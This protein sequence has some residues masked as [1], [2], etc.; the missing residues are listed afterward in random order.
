MRW[1]WIIGVGFLAGAVAVLAVQQ[2]AL[3]FFHWLGWAQN[4]PYRMNPTQP[5]GVAQVWSNAFFGGL[6]GIVLAAAASRF[7]MPVLL[8]GL[9][10]GAIALPLV[11]WFV[12]APIRGQPVAQ[13]FNLARMWFSPLING[14]WGLGAAFFWRA[15]S[16]A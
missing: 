3:G 1:A 2:P 15:F 12:V 14:I 9:L 7:R 4:P 8:L 13:G 16:R 11:G 5:F 6:W 10:V